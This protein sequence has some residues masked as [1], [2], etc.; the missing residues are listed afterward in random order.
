[1]NDGV[2]AVSARCTEFAFCL[3]SAKGSGN[4]VGGDLWFFWHGQIPC[5][6]CAVAMIS[7]I[8]VARGIVLFCMGW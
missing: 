3:T 8:G 7:Y 5:F 1:M 2:T 4:A 6:A